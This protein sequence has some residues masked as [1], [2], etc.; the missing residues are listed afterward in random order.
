MAAPEL[1]A[2]GRADARTDVWSA[3][4]LTYQLLTGRPAPSDL[5]PEA[6]EIESGSL[7]ELLA[8]ALSPNPDLRPASG[9]AL[10]EALSR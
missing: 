3:A 1:V 6:D 7:G 9:R 2:G 5:A 8:S 4:A 10:R